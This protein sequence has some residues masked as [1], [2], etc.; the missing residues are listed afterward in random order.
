MQHKI[1]RRVKNSMPQTGLFTIDKKLIIPKRLIFENNV[2][3]LTKLDKILIIKSYVIELK[4]SRIV[5]LFLNN[6]HPNCDPSTNL[7]CLPDY[8]IDTKITKQRLLLIENL[9]E[10]YNM[11]NCYWSPWKYISY[12]SQEPKTDWENFKTNVSNF[13]DKIISFEV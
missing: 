11:N 3:Y 2:Y 10:T 6:R 7:F 4:D 13:I 12:S 9:L 5:R 8:F 1:F